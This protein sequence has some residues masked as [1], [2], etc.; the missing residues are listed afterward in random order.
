M[1]IIHIVGL[2]NIEKTKFIKKY[3]AEKIFDLDTLFKISK[4]KETY[5]NDL[6]NIIKKNNKNIIFIGDSNNISVRADI[7][8]LI[9]NNIEDLIKEEIKSNIDINKADIINGVYDTKNIDFSRILSKKKS[10]YDQYKKKGYIIETFKKTCDIID[11]RNLKL[12]PD[13]LFICDEK[14]HVNKIISK[15]KIYA[16]TDLWFALTSSQSSIIKEKGLTDDNV[17]YIKIDKKILEKLKAST[18]L[19]VLKD[20]K[21]FIPIIKNGIVHKYYSLKPVKI[22]KSIFIDDIFLK[23]KEIGVKFLYNKK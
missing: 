4:S 22:N 10:I 19:Y 12:Y 2:N 14:Q 5:K 15:N 7:K 3:I 20:V 17:P 9:D 18:N 6:K 1:S 13:I 8:I 23:L 11:A 21:N 16:Y